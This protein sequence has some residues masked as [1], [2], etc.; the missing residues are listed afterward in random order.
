MVVSE[1]KFKKP[2]LAETNLS[3]Y[4]T[5][6]TLNKAKQIASFADKH[7]LQQLVDRA[8]KANE[9]YLILGAGSNVLFANDFE[10]NIF[11]DCTTG[12][13]IIEEDDDYVFLRIASGVDWHS[14]V[15][16]C[17]DMNYGGIE[18]L[19]LIPGKA[20][21]A[22]I[23]NIGAYGVELA[24]VLECV[25]F[26]HL[27]DFNTQTLDKSACK[28]SYRQSI[29]KEMSRGSFWISEIVLKL[30][31]RNHKLQVSYDALSSYFRLNNIDKISIK[32]IFDAVVK[33]RQS[34]LPD[35]SLIGNAGSFFKNPVIPLSQFD[36]LNLDFPG[37]PGWL[38]SEDRVKIPAAW[39]I[40]TL[41]FKGLRKGDAG[42]HEKHALVLVNY[43]N[44]KGDE[45]LS[46]A[47]SIS[48]SVKAQFGID[49]ASEVNIIY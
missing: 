41:G 13:N 17:V 46:I 48:A 1:I 47:N 7:E 34:K 19:A 9:K 45:I 5:F 20:G 31:K 21:A 26:Y 40:D 27:P 12:V 38:V 10:G 33:I 37:I 36:Q 2:A 24:D 8:F 42:V 15:S 32:L 28:F 18:N 25:S 22:P 49:L 4:H 39:L 14:L 30:T 23:Q 43:G 44:A 29:F 16:Q 3:P 11:I 6:S 35:P